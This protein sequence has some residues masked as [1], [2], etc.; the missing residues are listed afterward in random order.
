M[1]ED[2]EHRYRI[3][4]DGSGGDCTYQRKHQQKLT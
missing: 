2:S 1:N 3:G 4:A